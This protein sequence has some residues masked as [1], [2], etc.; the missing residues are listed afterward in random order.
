MTSVRLMH[1]A[2]R[3]AANP[4]HWTPDTSHGASTKKAVSAPDAPIQMPALDFAGLIK[5][6]NRT[7]NLIGYNVSYGGI[8]A[9]AE[10]DEL[11]LT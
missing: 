4:W 10:W 8:R 9:R 5:R 3:G 7:H 6:A 11:R 2:S 1:S